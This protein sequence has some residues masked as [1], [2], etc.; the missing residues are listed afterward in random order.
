[1]SYFPPSSAAAAL[2]D[3]HEHGTPRHL[4]LP[5]RGDDAGCVSGHFF[6]TAINISSFISIACLIYNYLFFLVLLFCSGD[7]PLASMFVTKVHLLIAAIVFRDIRPL[8]R[9]KRKS[10][11]L[12]R[13]RA[14]TAR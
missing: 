14:A 3:G 6:Y 8:P 9:P 1:M 5:E 12:F 2:A 4:L 7:N 13:R 10:F 11:P